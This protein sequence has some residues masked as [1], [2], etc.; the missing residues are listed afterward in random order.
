MNVN[1]GFLVAYDYE[2]LKESIPRVYNEASKIV[3]A[4]DH[5]QRTWAN[6]IYTIAPS[7]WEW[8]KNFDT[9]NKIEIYKDDFYDSTLTPMENE[10]RERQ[11]LANFM[12]EGVTIQLD[13]DEYF[14]NFEGFV[15]YIDKHK[16]K[17]NNT[18]KVQIC[19]FSINIY[20]YT[21]NGILTTPETCSFY[22]GTNSPD[23]IRGRKN[24]DQQKWYVPFICIHQSMGRTNEELEFK[25]KNWGHKDDF[26]GVDYFKKWQ[27][28]NESNYESFKNLHPLGSN[29]WKYLE[30]YKGTS[31]NDISKQLQNDKKLSPYFLWI[32]NMAQ[33]LKFIFK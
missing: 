20:K 28:I 14:V 30:Y 6:N 19:C 7:F 2:L 33:K 1:V 5:K 23:Y 24:K 18:K 15:K 11:M 10:T 22:I 21:K 8:I 3:L 25:L 26:D 16:K 29:S 17:L 9:K 4:V 13:A 32:K 31:L 12:G 27:Q